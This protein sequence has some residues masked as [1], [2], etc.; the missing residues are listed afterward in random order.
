MNLF[1]FMASTKGGKAKII[2]ENGNF[3]EVRISAVKGKEPLDV[4][5]EK[6]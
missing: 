1:M 3:K 6:G 5:N 2:Y 4:R